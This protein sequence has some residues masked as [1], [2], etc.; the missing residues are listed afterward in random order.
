[1]IFKFKGIDIRAFLI[2]TL[3]RGRKFNNNP[4]IRRQRDKQMI[5]FTTIISNTLRLSGF[6]VGLPLIIVAEST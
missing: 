6:F 3:N 5:W 1:M 2:S 4:L